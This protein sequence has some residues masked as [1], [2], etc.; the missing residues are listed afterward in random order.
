ML[1]GRIRD[2][3]LVLSIVPLAFLI[4]LLLLV[5]ILERRTEDAARWSEHS[6]IVL[7]QSDRTESQLV[8]VN[9][10]AITYVRTRRP[11]DRARFSRALGQL[12]SSLDRLQVLVKDNPPQEVRAKN[13]AGALRQAMNVLNVYVAY[14]SAGKL[15]EA[16]SL[17]AS[18]KTRAL[19]DRLTSTRADFDAA[20]R[21]L[22]IQRFST[23]RGQLAAFGAIVIGVT[24]LGIVVTL[25]TTARFGLRLAQRL[26]QLAENA[27]LLGAGQDPPR[28]TG[29]DEVADLDRVYQDMARRLRRER[30]VARTLQHALLPQRTPVVPGIEITAAYA[31]ATR[32][33]DIGGDWYD[34]FLL[35]DD[36]LALSVGD[37]VGSGLRA[38]TVMGG[39]RQSIRTAARENADPEHVMRVANRMLCADGWIASAV[40]VV[41]DVR[42]GEIAVASAGHPPPF[43]ARNSTV[44]ALQCSGILLGVLDDARYDVCRTTLDDGSLLVLYTDGLIEADQDVIGGIER[45]GA[46]VGDSA[47]QTASS[48]ARAIQHRVFERVR[49]RDDSAVLTVRVSRPVSGANGRVSWT[50]DARDAEA[51]RRVRHEMVQFITGHAPESD[52]SNAEL[53]FSELAGNI[54]R[55]TPGPA[56]FSLERRKRSI[57]MK[58]SDVGDP[59][60]YDGRETVDPFAE[61]GRGLF[62]VHALAHDMQIERKG[63]ENTVTVLLAL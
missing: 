22:A 39:V 17:D 33:S 55:H 52:F 2:Q 42:S 60:A 8:T 7:N 16:Q 21:D 63:N 12:E 1:T 61:G 32:A 40:Y 41:M 24:L 43:L 28:M 10:A 11:A 35:S 31:P 15:R 57:V 23:L 36:L 25:F 48:P 56:R 53:I 3:A 13:Y 37:V 59:F 45:L 9:T 4:V 18:P 58:M 46:I 51:A 49:A 26:L 34:A 30:R 19:A 62:L 54:A 20:E 6:A 14:V 38:A 5:T 27:R 44:S 50:F 29:N 47:V